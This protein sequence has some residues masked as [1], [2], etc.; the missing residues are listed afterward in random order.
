MWFSIAIIFRSLF[1]FPNNRVTDCVSSFHDDNLKC[2]KVRINSDFK[3]LF[4][5][6]RLPNLL[7]SFSHQDRR[8]SLDQ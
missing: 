5:D 4:L 6:Y 2:N 8:D 7:G 1:A 3:F